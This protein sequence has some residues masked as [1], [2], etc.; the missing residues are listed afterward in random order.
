MENPSSAKSSPRP[1]P[2]EW[3]PLES[4]PE[5]FSEYMWN[6]GLPRTWSI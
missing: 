2:F 4:N 3:P 6:V 1:P 5:V